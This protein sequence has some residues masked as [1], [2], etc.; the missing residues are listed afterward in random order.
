MSAVRSVLVV[1]GGT[2]GNTLAILL[3][4]A[5]IA[6]DLVEIDPAWSAL[7]SGI[8][9]QGNA[10]RVLDEAGV[11]P[12]V[13]DSIVAA[14]PHMD[15][16]RL[17][18]DAYP[19]VCGM[20]RPTL[21]RILTTEVLGLGTH[22]RLGTTF[23]TIDER[24]DQVEVTFTDG[25]TRRYD[26]VIGAD[27][28]RSAVRA[29]LGIDVTPQATGMAIWRVCTR[30]PE[31]VEHGV[32]GH[33]GQFYVTGINPTS[34]T[35]L[36]A[37]VVEEARDRDTVRALD[38]VAEMRRLTAHLEGHWPAIR[39]DITDPGQVD[40]RLFEYLSVPW[41]WNRGRVMIIGD[42]AHACPPTLAQGAAQGLEDA[43]VLAQLLASRDEFGGRLLEE[44]RDRR[45][46]RAARVVSA[47]VQMCDLLRRPGGAGQAFGVMTAVLR[48]LSNPWEA[49]HE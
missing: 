36:Y 1:G 12:Q 17:G 14:P 18:G 21:Q 10:L 7:G 28:I 29:H 48:D 35:S 44:F 16:V 19:G 23:T 2:V 20:H 46:A 42:A 32:V 34:A 30:R 40:Y 43:S 37:Y 33:G 5:G 9:L 24:D 3:R 15:R 39:A 22:V 11:W 6:V 4:R 13:R 8:T 31:S 49:I 45:A 38:P 47:S 26:L 41:P 25:E 27:G